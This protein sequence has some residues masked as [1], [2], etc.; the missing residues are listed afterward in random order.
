M[1]LRVSWV[2]QIYRA[3]PSSLSCKK[4]QTNSRVGSGWVCGAFT[5]RLTVGTFCFHQFAPSGER[6]GDAAAM[7]V[8]LRFW[9]GSTRCAAPESGRSSR[10]C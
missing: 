6:L 3:L 4:S 8:A 7:S 9:N 2:T 5:G 10:G 1:P